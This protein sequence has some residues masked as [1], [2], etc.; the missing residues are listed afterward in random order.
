M[1]SIT[2]VSDEEEGEEHDQKR[3]V[4]VWFQIPP[5]QTSLPSLSFPSPHLE[6]LSGLG[7]VSS[8]QLSAAQ[9]QTEAPCTGEDKTINWGMTTVMGPRPGQRNNRENFI[10]ENS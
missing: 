5:A 10:S 4:P 8:L 1:L 3:R 2:V 9:R 7:K 6:L